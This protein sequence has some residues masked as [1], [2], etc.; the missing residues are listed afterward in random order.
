MG[1][2]EKVGVD[3]V[4]WGAKEAP[5]GVVGAAVAG[6]AEEGEGWACILEKA[7]ERRGGR[8]RRQLTRPTSLSP[9][10]VEA[11]VLSF[12]LLGGVRRVGKQVLRFWVG[13]G[14]EGKKG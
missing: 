12:S 13:D 8:G 9:S 1:Q 6:E 14:R 4:S 10:F 2:A 7:R 11:R 3:H 5:M